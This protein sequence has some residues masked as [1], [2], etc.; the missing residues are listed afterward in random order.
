MKTRVWRSVV[1]RWM[2]VV[3]MVL[4]ATPALAQQTYPVFLTWDAP[5]K[6]T[7][8]SNYTDPDG[9]NVYWGTAQGTYPN[10]VRVPKTAGDHATLN[11]TAGM[12]FF[13]VT[14]LNAGARESDQ[15]NV[16][17]KNVGPVPVPPTNT[18][19]GM[20]VTG[21]EPLAYVI[22]QTTDDITLVP[23][24]TVSTGTPCNEKMFAADEAH[25]VMFVVPKARVTFAGDAD[26]ELVFARCAAP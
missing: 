19:S 18:V 21:S 16:A 24:G 10:K 8:G 4:T 17:S 13:V 22:F 14:A 1:G 2:G 5:L 23:V 3:G 26:A 6:N 12:K 9:Y 25:G 7:D 20:K 11:L 15:S